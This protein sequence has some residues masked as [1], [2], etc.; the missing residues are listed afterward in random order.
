MK[1]VNLPHIRPF[2]PAWLVALLF[3]CTACFPGGILDKGG[4]TGV[5]GIIPAA[6]NLK[7]APFKIVCFDKE[8]AL[9]REQERER[10]AKA[11]EKASGTVQAPP[12]KYVDA[13]KYKGGCEEEGESSQ[14]VLFGMWPVTGKLNPEY[15]MSMAVQR[16]EGDTMINIRTWHEAH[17]YSII[18]RA[19]VFKARGDVIKFL[20]VEEQQ[21]RE[22]GKKKTGRGNVP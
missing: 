10:A 6:S 15:A 20:S 8:E 3:L 5:V 2:L 16:L 17:F 11:G 13:D 12:V 18:G 14:F 21:E 9:R 4:S 7:G 22:K 19:V 1:R